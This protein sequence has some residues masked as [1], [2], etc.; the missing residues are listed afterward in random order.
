M[1]RCAA[2]CRWLGSS[3]AHASTISR[4][5]STGPGDGGGLS[6]RAEVPVE[7]LS[8]ADIWYAWT[9]ITEFDEQGQSVYQSSGLEAARRAGYRVAI[10]E[11][12]WNGQWRRR[13]RR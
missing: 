8:A 2:W 11:W 13:S 10:T 3:S 4:R 5:I 6:R 9:A 7:D 12:N 1:A